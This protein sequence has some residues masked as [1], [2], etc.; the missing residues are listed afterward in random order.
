MSSR[1]PLYDD[2]LLAESYARVSASNVANA[3]YERP[4]LRALAGDVS[5]REVLDA[6]CAAGEHSAWLVAQGARVTALDASPAMVALAGE[7]LGSAVR[8]VHADLGAALPFDDAAFDLVVSS[9][10]LHYLRDWTTPLREFKRV[11]RPGGRLV[12]STHHPHMT[13][14]DVAVYHDVSLVE[15]HWSAFA[16]EPVPVRYYHRPL[17]QIVNPVIACGFALRGLFE[18]QPTAEAQARDPRLAERFRTQP[19]FLLVVAEA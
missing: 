15:E 8:V 13:A 18:P 4:A 5:G 12:F 16:V 19:G 9:L 2:P 3:A 1:Q 10:T 11:L 7:R 14:G 6:G 17:Q